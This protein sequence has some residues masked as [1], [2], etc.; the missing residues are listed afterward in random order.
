MLYKAINELAPPGIRWKLVSMKL[1]LASRPQKA[2]D[3][4]AVKNSRELMI[5]FHRMGIL[6]TALDAEG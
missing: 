1:E 5:V 3:A 6:M 4:N 2:V